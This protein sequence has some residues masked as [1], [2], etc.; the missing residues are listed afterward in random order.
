MNILF[1]ADSYKK[2]HEILVQSIFRCLQRAGHRAETEIRPD[3]KYDCV[4][5]FNKKNFSIVRQTP[6]LGQVPVIFAFCISDTP[7]EYTVDLGLFDHTIIFEDKTPSIPLH[8]FNNKSFM[9]MLYGSEVKVNTDPIKE[10]PGR[11]AIYVGIDNDYF[12]EVV[13]LKIL[14]LLNQLSHYDFYCN[15]I[16]K[17]YRPLLNRNV[18][19]L[20]RKHDP[21][22]YIQKSRLVIGSGYTIIRALLANKKAIVTGEKGFGG[23]VNQENFGYHFNNFFQGR[24]GGKYDEY[25][26]LDLLK[27]SIE[28]MHTPSLAEETRCC[29][30][31]NQSYFIDTIERVVSDHRKMGSDWENTPLILKKEYLLMHHH[32][33]YRIVNHLLGTF[34]KRINEAECAI[35]SKFHQ[36]CT[37]RSILDEYP[38]YETEITEFIH[39]L[40][41]MK[42]LT[43]YEGKERTAN[44]SRHVID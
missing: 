27:K 17:N 9:R 8:P 4:L 24:N 40:I 26:P 28:D 11:P 36:G 30:E 18:K 44:K 42:I 12:G 20:D 6:A 31:A 25:I 21:T 15:Y 22:T 2:N 5:I 39:E 33:C 16:H 3:V 14:P 10:I 29:L 32:N 1:L 35:L 13:F 19:L 41:A 23:I 38:E 37:P 43:C 34:H 7:R